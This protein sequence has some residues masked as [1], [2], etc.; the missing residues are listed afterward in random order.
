MP[1]KTLTFPVPCLGSGATPT[2]KAQ[3]APLMAFHPVPALRGPSQ[4]LQEAIQDSC[5]QRQGSL[6]LNLLHSSQNLLMALPICM[7]GT[8][9]SKPGT[10]S[11]IFV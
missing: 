2:G 1:P 9:F 7:A 5:I 10:V 4:L 11:F 3:L 6:P 8:V